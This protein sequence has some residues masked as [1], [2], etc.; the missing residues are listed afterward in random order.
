MRLINELKANGVISGFFVLV[1]TDNI[2]SPVGI[3]EINNIIDI[4]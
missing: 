4:K 2:K 1:E 3:E